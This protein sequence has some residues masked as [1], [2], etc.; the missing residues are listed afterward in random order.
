MV[1]SNG[2][3]ATKIVAEKVGDALTSPSFEP[4]SLPLYVESMALLLA[5]YGEE[6]QGLIEPMLATVIPE[7]VRTRDNFRFLRMMQRAIDSYR[8]G[9]DPYEIML[10]LIGQ[11]RISLE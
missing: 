5:L 10:R 8:A 11:M 2:T 4:F 9:K 1:K 7:Y 3:R 6:S